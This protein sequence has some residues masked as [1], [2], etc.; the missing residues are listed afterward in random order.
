MFHIEKV[1]GHTYK[2]KGTGAGNLPK[3]LKGSFSSAWEAEKT[4]TSY[5][6][7]IEKRKEDIKAKTLARKASRKIK[8]DG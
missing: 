7:L 5:L 3:I 2:I 8:S 1:D 4:L 6:D